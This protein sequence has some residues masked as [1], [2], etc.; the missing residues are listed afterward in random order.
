MGNGL[1]HF[2]DFAL[3]SGHGAIVRHVDFVPK[4]DIARPLEMKEAAN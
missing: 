3:N 1:I 4:D 2:R